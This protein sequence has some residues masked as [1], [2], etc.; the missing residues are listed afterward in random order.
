MPYAND[1][2]GNLG[3]SDKLPQS[4]CSCS[5]SVKLPSGCLSLRSK[6]ELWSTPQVLAESDR[7]SPPHKAFLEPRSPFSLDFAAASPARLSPTFGG[8]SEGLAGISER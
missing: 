4:D 1:L 2:C 5:I 8:S 7:G 3:L 6:G